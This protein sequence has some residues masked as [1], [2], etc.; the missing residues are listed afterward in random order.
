MKAF[1]QKIFNFLKA[2]FF[3]LRV[4]V[5]LQL[6]GDRV[7]EDGSNPGEDDTETEKGSND[8]IKHHE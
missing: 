8:E 3:R 4:L 1:I 7:E 6:G 5:T 2:L